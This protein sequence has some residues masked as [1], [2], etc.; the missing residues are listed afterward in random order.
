MNHDASRRDADAER[1]RVLISAYRN[2]EDPDLT[3]LSRAL[4]EILYG[5]V[6]KLTISMKKTEQHRLLE[7]YLVDIGLPRSAD[8]QYIAGPVLWYAREKHVLPPARSDDAEDGSW[9][10]KEALF[11]E[12]RRRLEEGRVSFGDWMTNALQSLLAEQQ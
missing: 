8:L 12:G 10:L 3:G 9:T 4:W 1:I 11:E 2:G 5:L 6:P 7:G